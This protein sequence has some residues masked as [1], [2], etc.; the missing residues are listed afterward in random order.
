MTKQR[1]IRLSEEYRIKRAIFEYFAVARHSAD[2]D[3][4]LRHS[5]RMH[6]AEAD[7]YEALIALRRAKAGVA[8]FPG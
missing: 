5:T 1:V 7:M 3:Q 4:V 8:G 6:E 2:P